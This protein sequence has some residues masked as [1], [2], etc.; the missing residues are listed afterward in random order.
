MSP[1]PKNASGH[2]GVLRNHLRAPDGEET[3]C[4][5]MNSLLFWLKVYEV[6][7]SWCTVLSVTTP[8][9]N[10]NQMSGVHKTLD[11]RLPFVRTSMTSVHKV[12]SIFL[13]TNHSLPFCLASS[14]FF[15]SIEEK[16]QSKTLLVWL[17]LFLHCDTL[18]KLSRYR[19]GWTLGVPGG[20]DSRISRQSAHEGGKVVSA[21]HRPSLPPGK[22]LGTHF[23]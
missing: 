22:I 4:G 19:P 15:I 7:S 12:P 18:K 23:C 9:W 21:T 8:S 20:W 2:R 13:P 17:R 16:N 11:I 3:P 6:S 5:S 1:V 10:N 14:Y